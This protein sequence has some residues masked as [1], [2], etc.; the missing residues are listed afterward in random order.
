MFSSSIFSRPFM[1]DDH[2][3]DTNEEAIKEII[4]GTSYL[5]VFSLSRRDRNQFSLHTIRVNVLL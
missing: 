4:S 1:V 2:R 5:R 3:R